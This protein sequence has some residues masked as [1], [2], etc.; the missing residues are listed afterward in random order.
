MSNS[1]EV[2]LRFASFENVGKDAWNGLVGQSEFPSVFQSFGWL[3]SWW[4]TFREPSWELLLLGISDGKRLFGLA[5]LFSAPA[6]VRWGHQRVV[7][8]VGDEHADYSTF[9]VEPGRPEVVALCIE[10][11]QRLARRGTRVELLEVPESTTLARTLLA[12][13]ARRASRMDL[14]HTTECPRVA[15]AGDEEATKRLLGKDSLK[16][17][18]S[19]LRKLGA[20]TVE[21]LRQAEQIAPLLDR[22]FH[23]HIA[24]WSVTSYPSLFLKA[25]NR[26]FYE[27][28]VRVLAP[29]GYLVFTVLKLD[30]TPVAFHL[31][32]RSYGD[33]Y[34]YKPSFEIR[35]AHV[36]PGEVMLRELFVMAS[37]EGYAAFDFLRGNEPF[38]RRFAS[39]NRTNLSFVIRRSAIEQRIRR[40]GRWMKRGIK[41][42]LVR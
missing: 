42:A 29:D 14:V 26:E 13:G 11:L 27:R 33:F 4:E 16:R 17:H 19:K 2:L 39:S 31:G 3:T 35:L 9:I 7:R 36:S 5:P 12:M 23:Q 15:L 22:F 1:E 24:R 37:S 20:V 18:T 21:H 6:S 41:T 34:W 28:L 40:A 30:G 32:F 25:K 8:F 38:K 10:E